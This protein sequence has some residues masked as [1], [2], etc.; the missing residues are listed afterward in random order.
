MKVLLHLSERKNVEKLNNLEYLWRSCVR[1]SLE[2]S[3][4]LS[5]RTEKYLIEWKVL[6]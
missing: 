3:L 6:S 5:I 4:S 2:G 1:Y